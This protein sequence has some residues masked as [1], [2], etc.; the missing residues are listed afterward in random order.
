MSTGLPRE[1]YN[2]LSERAGVLLRTLVALHIR[3]GQPVGS[4]TLGEEAGLRV[5]PATIR[6]AMAELEDLGFLRSP[7]T[8]AGRVPTAQGYRFFV[9][10]VL[11][12]REPPEAG[13]LSTLRSGLDPDRDARELLQS[14][15]SLLSSITSQAGLVTVPRPARQPLRQVEFLPLS[16]DRVLVILV[17]NRRE[18]QNRI[19]HTRRVFSESELKDAAQLLNERFA[20]RELQDVQEELEREMAAARSRL[21]GFLS[22]SL[23]LAQTALA[24]DDSSQDCLIVGESRLFEGASAEELDQLRQLLSALERKQDLLHLLERCSVAD[25]VKIFIGEEAGAEA[26]GDYS[27]VTAPYGDGT[28]RLGVL[29]V[30]GPTR[31]AYD[32]VIPIVD[33]T[34]RMLTRALAG[35]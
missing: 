9:D 8:S 31:M 6:N 21:D 19:I 1:Q 29:G 15:S 35:S 20:G 30:I 14:A 16:G 27:F 18:V 25:G 4:R 2:D 7:H 26:F 22:D 24:E 12:L 34:S 3:D 33:V 11:Q 23:E 17:L 5:S 32:R 10:T 13:D 28:R